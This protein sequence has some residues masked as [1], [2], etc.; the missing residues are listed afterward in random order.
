MDNTEF[1]V[2]FL[3]AS[4]GK[5]IEADIPAGIS[6]WQQCGSSLCVTLIL[7]SPIVPFWK[8]PTDPPQKIP[9]I[10]PTRELHPSPPPPSAADEF[11]Q[12][13]AQAVQMLAAAYQNQPLPEVVPEKADASLTQ[14]HKSLIF[15]LNRSGA[16]E[17]MRESLKAPLLRIVREELGASGSMSQ[18]EMRPLYGKL[19]CRLMDLLHLHLSM[20]DYQDGCYC[21]SKS[22]I[23]I[24]MLPCPSCSV[25]DQSPKPVAPGSSTSDSS[26]HLI[27]LDLQYEEAGLWMRSSGDSRGSV[28][29]ERAEALH[30]ARLVDRDN[31]QVK[32]CNCSGP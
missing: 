32:K 16:Y 26:L 9:D 27:Q 21:L 25:A 12:Q 8:A 24:I 1:Y 6:A 10:I 13:I 14:R 3:R 15:D 29:L 5:P 19:Y 30:Q 17:S 22:H 11:R 2:F 28:L 20:C 23:L 7:T 31:V 4:K 18:T